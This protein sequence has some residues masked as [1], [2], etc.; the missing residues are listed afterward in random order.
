MSSAVLPA[1]NYGRD[2]LQGESDV[3]TRMQDLRAEGLGFD[4]VAEQLNVE[5]LK[6]RTGERWWG[7][8]VN[9]ILSKAAA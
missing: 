4:R 9:N 1:F 3:L 6:P 8:T 7:R 2:T 5:G